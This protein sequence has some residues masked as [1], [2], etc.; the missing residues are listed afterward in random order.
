M[1]I[2]W[3]GTGQIRKTKDQLSETCGC[4]IDFMERGTIKIGEEPIKMFGNPTTA[5]ITARGIKLYFET[6]PTFEQIKALNKEL[7]GYK[8][9]Y[10]VVPFKD[11]EIRD[12]E[13]EVDEL[14]SKVAKLEKK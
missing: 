11:G 9:D 14:K 10:S 6:E 2:V 1:E 4:A 13:K 8:R 5:P 12:L 3:F 7:E